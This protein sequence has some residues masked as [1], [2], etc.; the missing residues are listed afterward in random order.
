MEKPPAIPLQPLIDGLAAHVLRG[1]M[2]RAK[3]EE[4]IAF[5]EEMDPNGWLCEAVLAQIRKDWGLA[6]PDSHSEP[7]WRCEGHGYTV[8]QIQVDDFIERRCPDC[9]GTGERERE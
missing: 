7:C 5:Y 6:P 3:A 1:E 2:P 8:H 4:I 9:D